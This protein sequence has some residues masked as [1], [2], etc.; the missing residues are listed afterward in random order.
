M[1]ASPIRVLFV[2]P[3][4]R[5]GGAERH[6]ATL[7]PRMNPERFTPSLVCIGEE[8]DLFEEVKSA[9]IAA[10]ALHLGGKR[11][12]L[13][14]LAALVSHMRRTRPDVVVVWGY[15]AEV[16][17]RIAARIARV[18]HSVVWVH[19]AIGAERPNS[20][21][22]LAARALIPWTRAFFGV[23]E[24]QRRFITDELRC[25][26]EKVRII[27]NGVDSN[28]FAAD[29]GPSARTEFGIDEAD[30]VVGIVAALRAEKDHATLL[31]AAKKVLA[32]RPRT[33]FLLVG[34]GP[35]RPD[36]EALSS[37]LG[38]SSNVR[39]AGS[40]SDVVRL[41]RGMDVFVLCSI[42]ECFPISVLEAMACA[43]PVVCTDVGGI[44]EMVD[45]GV[46]GYLVPVGQPR[47][48][49]DRINDILSNRELASRLGQ[50]GRLRV[51]SEF[52]VEQSVWATEREIEAVVRSSRASPMGEG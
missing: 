15:N 16:L 3:D 5:F 7:L 31:R 24:A 21:R 6:V 20:P 25:P 33:I 26:P 10:E 29:D 30:D 44:R 22:A 36:L 2:V 13:R 45:D 46:S 35:T 49:A 34:D 1:S 38:I 39:F 18:K 51:E 4:L 12:A 47:R 50:A 37:E 40:R 9:G 28:Q 42:T 43:R 23:A 41:L 32:D 19:A 52:T 48:L 8:G 11:D 27:H 14:A 17:G